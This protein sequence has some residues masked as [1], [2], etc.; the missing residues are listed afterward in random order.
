MLPAP[1]ER[2]EICYPPS[3]FVHCDKPY[4]SAALNASQT[5]L[6]GSIVSFRNDPF[7]Y[8]V[9]ECLDYHSDGGVLI[10]NGKI[11]AVGPFTDI[12]KIA[13]SATSSVHYPHSIISAGFI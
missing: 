3:A 8:P 1:M 7:L 4:R 5:L 12:A 9:R 2:A 6:R 10:E 11:A 13:H